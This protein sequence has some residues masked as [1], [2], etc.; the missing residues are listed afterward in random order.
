MSSLLSSFYFGKPHVA[1]TGWIY[2]VIEYLF[3]KEQANKKQH[4]GQGKPITL[5]IGILIVSYS[6][7]D[8][9][10]VQWIFV[11]SLIEHLFQYFIQI[12][13]IHFLTETLKWL[14]NCSRISKLCN[15][16]YFLALYHII[17]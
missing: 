14:I 2:H 4:L 3:N 6:C 11:I 13:R 7:L 12:F 16:L 1:T 17:H 8:F 10:E 9:D 5:F 15:L